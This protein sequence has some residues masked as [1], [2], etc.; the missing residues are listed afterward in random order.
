MTDTVELLAPARDLACGCTAIDCGADAVYV[1]APRF[2]ARAKVGNS[3]ADIQ[4]LVEYAHQYW[5]R[6]YV[7]VNTVLFDAELTEAVTLIHSLHAM[8]VDGIIIQD[9]GLLEC[10]L[11]PVPLI[12]STQMDIRT[13]EKAVFLEKIGFKRAILARELSLDQIHAIRQATQI[14]LE[15]FVH[16]AL[17]VCYSGQCF[18]SYALGARSANRGECAQPCRQRYRLVDAEG[19]TICEDRYLLSPKDLNLSEELKPLLEAGVRSFKIEGRLKDRAYVANVVRHYRTH[20]DRLLPGMGLKTSS[21]GRVTSDFTPDI[22]KT[23][24]RGYTTAFLH[25]RGESVGSIDTPKMQGERLGRIISLDRKGF[26]LDGTVTVHPGDGLCFFRD[27]ELCGALVNGVQGRRILPNRM[28]GL[29]K[30]LVI[31]R[32]H[33]HAFLRQ[34]NRARICREIPVTLRLSETPDGFCLS[35]E[36]EQGNQVSVTLSAEKTPAS[37]PDGAGASLRK[38][39]AKTGKTIFQCTDI[40]VQWQQPCFLPVSVVNG[41]RRD[42]LEALLAERA[43]KRPMDQGAIQK[44]SV[45]YP[46]REITFSGN[47]INQKAR[48]FYERH[49]AKVVEPGAESG[50]PM[51]GR[52][53]MTTQYCLRDQLG[54]CPRQGKSR[55]YK[56]PFY[57][58]DAQG[59]RF[60]VE[61]DCQAC[62]M[63]IRFTDP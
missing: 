23:F 11:P 8:G 59:H 36:D 19:K 39:L 56:E 15:A 58:V 22:A 35:A 42:V 10:D 57:L 48:A 54:L 34:L 41:L 6:V 1:G 45:P 50:L 60:E 46:D 26:E 30:G 37:D 3:L 16:G 61:F 43:R 49:G 53:V 31:Y 5:A 24:N 28:Q 33:D 21:S 13:P 52:T 25:G 29:E 63:V 27:G 51:Q 12:A 55:A 2:G 4:A 9:V 38:Q 62:Q 20:L 47:V 32:N 44:N 40:Q 7:T 14:E 17:C 18:M